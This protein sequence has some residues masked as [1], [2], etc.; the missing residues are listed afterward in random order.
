MKPLDHM[1]KP[2]IAIAT[3]VIQLPYTLIIMIIKQEPENHIA[4]S[5]NMLGLKN[6]VNRIHMQIKHTRGT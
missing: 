5:E 6:M 4:I 1:I 3:A 2:I